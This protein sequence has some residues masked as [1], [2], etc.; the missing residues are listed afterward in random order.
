ML[1]VFLTK[2]NIQA[3][4]SLSLVNSR[5]YAWKIIEILRNCTPLICYFIFFKDP[6]CLEKKIINSKTVYS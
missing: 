1:S 6:L 2:D 4:G 5:W 3:K